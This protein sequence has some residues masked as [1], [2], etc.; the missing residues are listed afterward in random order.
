MIG[1]W[2]V[3]DPYGQYWSS[4][5][6]MGNNP[7]SSVDPD[8]GCT[9]GDCDKGAATLSMDSKGALYTLPEIEVSGQFEGSIGGSMERLHFVGLH[10]PW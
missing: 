3:P 1:R 2:L 4:Y 6:G 8:G 9:G 7:V 10:R 5:L